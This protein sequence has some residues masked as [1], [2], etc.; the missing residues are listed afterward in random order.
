MKLCFRIF[1]IV[2]VML[3]LIQ[4]T[5]SAQPMGTITAKVGDEVKL[6]VPDEYVIMTSWG[7]E[8]STDETKAVK[9]ETKNIFHC[10]VTLLPE[11]KN[12]D[13]IN[14]YFY[15]ETSVNAQK[16]PYMLWWIIE[17]EKDHVKSVSLNYTS[18]TLDVGETKQLTATVSPSN[19]KTQSVYP[20]H[21]P[22]KKSQQ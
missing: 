8:W 11:A 7:W 20:G 12:Y 6:D 1:A 9:L 14:V 5:V 18:L 19:T 2:A 4:M 10:H 16:T 15:F 3:T 21:L 22:I 13:Y 17:V